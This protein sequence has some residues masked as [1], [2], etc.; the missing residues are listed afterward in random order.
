VS[1]LGEVRDRAGVVIS[2]APDNQSDPSVTFDGTN[3]VVAWTDE[4]NISSRDVYGSRVTTAGSVLDPAGI[5]IATGAGEQFQPAISSDETSSLVV[6][7]HLGATPASDIRAARVG[8]SGSVLDV[9]G[10]A[11]ST[12]ADAQSSPAVAFDGRNWLVIWVDRRSGNS[13]DIYGA[14][15][16]PSATVLDPTGRAVSA[17]A[18]N[19]TAPAVAF[20]GTNSLVVWSDRRP[21]TTFDIYGAR[22]DQ[23]GQVLDAGR[24]R[25]LHG[26]RQPDVPCGRL[27]RHPVPRCVA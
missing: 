4:R 9:G 5:P 1:K 19:Q 2:S 20:D 21:G 6:W 15:V 13:D 25:R 7:T 16:T 18:R 17:A 12:A 11:I 14:R 3:F 23:D 26:D 24:D 8:P 27:R 22:V 10:F